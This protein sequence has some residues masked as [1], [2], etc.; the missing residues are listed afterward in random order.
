MLNCRS[1]IINPF[2]VGLGWTISPLVACPLMKY[3]DVPGVT[4]WVGVTGEGVIGLAGVAD[5]D[6]GELADDPP[7]LVATELTV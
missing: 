5:A 4:G 1:E 6:C 7:A 3:C 2:A